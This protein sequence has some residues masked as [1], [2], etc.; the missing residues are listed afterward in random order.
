MLSTEFTDVG[1]LV[2]DALTYCDMTTSPTGATVDVDTR[3]SEILERYGETDIVAQS[4]EESRSRIMNSARNV[5]S[6][7]R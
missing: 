4:I 6:A 2:A 5:V 1:G 3:L 7:L